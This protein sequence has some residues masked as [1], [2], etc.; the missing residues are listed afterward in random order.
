MKGRLS[1]DRIDELIRVAIDLGFY[2]RREALFLGIPQNFRSTM[3]Q[4]RVSRDQLATDVHHLNTTGI[5]GSGVDPF[6]LWLG[7]AIE[8]AGG[9]QD[10]VVFRTAI[11]ELDQLAKDP[12]DASRD[13]SSRDEFTGSSSRTAEASGEPRSSIGS[14]R[15]KS[16][17]VTMPMPQVAKATQVTVVRWL[18]RPGDHVN[19]DET[20]LEVFAEKVDIEI[21]C[22]ATGYLRRIYVPEDEVVRV[23]EPLALIEED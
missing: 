5:L 19:M 15:R 8:A 22:S 3:P 4:T 2:E 21:P 23:G 16:G 13:P 9:V 1:P 20:I 11:A 6:K 18:K 7:N 17:L 10:D 12:R 14:T